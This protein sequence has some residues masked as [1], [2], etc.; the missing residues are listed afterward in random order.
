MNILKN[1][2]KLLLIFILSLL[3]TTLV[4]S[5]IYYLIGFNKTIITYFFIK[6]Q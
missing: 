3:A 2:I 1:N 5:F 6:L 4:I